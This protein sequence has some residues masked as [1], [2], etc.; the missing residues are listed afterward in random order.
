MADEFRTSE[1]GERYAR[2]LFDLALETRAL[3]AVRADLLSLTSAWRD[4]ADLRRLLASPLLASADQARGL[5]AVAEAAKV[6]APTCKFLR[7]RPQ[8]GRARDLPA[9]LA[10]FG[11]LYARHPGGVA[12]EVVSA[13]PL[14][15]AQLKAV[16]AGLRE[17]LGKDPELT[18][19]VD[20]SLLGGLKVKVG[21]RLFDASLKTRLDQ[22]KFALK[23]A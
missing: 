12:A 1:V 2:A 20:P 6:H 5:T 19:R 8:G 13:A 15:A 22:M 23:R 21:S 14:G 10:A 16:K 18:A 9:A 11:A 3:E 7:L 17:A 4:S